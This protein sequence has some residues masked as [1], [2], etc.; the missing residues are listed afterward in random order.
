MKPIFAQSR[1]DGWLVAVALFD[2]V[3][4]AYV[5]LRFGRIGVA[6][7]VVMA[8]G[9][10]FL[11]C[12]NYQCVAHNFIHNPFF[13]SSRLNSL[14]SLF[15]SLS[16]KM[17]QTL[18]RAQ[19]LHH[20]KYNNDAKASAT[21][22]TL[23]QT[24]TYRYG[25]AGREEHIIPYAL[26]GLVRSDIGYFGKLAAK[27]GRRRLLVVETVAIAAYFV[28]LAMANWRGVVFFLLPV[29]YLG[30]VGA[31]A[32]NYLEHHLATPGNRL[33]D[34]VS[35]YGTVYN[36]IW[37][38]NGYHQEHHYRPTVHWTKIAALR[39]Q[40]LPEAQRRVVRGAHWWNFNVTKAAT[41]SIAP[42]PSRVTG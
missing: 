20:H 23:D 35:A 30:L 13:S 24:S 25:T 39:V 36:L 32:E 18:Y 8:A 27:Q 7:A 9:L 21:D 29:W 15:N 40:M 14:F 34:S 37:F 26:L 22:T 4:T 17:P 3:L 38:N 1:R 42:A 5:T 31:L 33:T 28:F 41:A 10:V 2:V 11:N 19:H 12:T 16:L 6:P